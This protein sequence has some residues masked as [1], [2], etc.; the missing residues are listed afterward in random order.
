MMAASVEPAAGRH[1]MV[2][3][4]AGVEAGL[5]HRAADFG[6]RRQGTARNRAALD[7]IEAQL[8][9]HGCTN[10]ERL[11]SSLE[12]MIPNY[13]HLFDS[14]RGHGLMLGLKLKSDSRRFVEFARDNHG[15]LLVS[16]GYVGLLFAVAYYGD[17]RERSPRA[18][19]MW[20]LCGQPLKR[21]T[22]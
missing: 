10:T 2:G 14:V 19:V 6:D 17:Q 4:E 5:F 13:D 21:S 1:R 20:P 18:S 7:W 16:A 22:A 8:K 3:D 9:R 15:L 12:Q 11:R